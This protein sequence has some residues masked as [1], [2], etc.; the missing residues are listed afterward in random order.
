MIVMMG[1]GSECVLE[2]IA[3]NKNVGLIKVRL[4]RPFDEQAFIKSLPK[5]VKK[6]IVLDRTRESGAR[7]PLYLDVKNALFGKDIQVVGGVYGLGG[8]EF[9][10][11]EAM[12]VIN[13]FE[14]MRDDFSVGITDDVTLKSLPE[15]KAQLNLKQTEIK[16]YGLG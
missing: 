1:S 9:S 2:C 12:A 6:I 3:Q 15:V 13:N 10:P 8:K 14:S 5:N 7:E 11:N 4:Y 16:I